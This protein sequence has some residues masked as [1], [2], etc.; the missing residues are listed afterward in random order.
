MLAKNF[1]TEVKEHTFIT[2]KDWKN[3]NSSFL[4]NSRRTLKIPKNRNISLKKNFEKISEGSVR[5]F[6]HQWLP[7][8]KWVENIDTRYTYSIDQHWTRIQDI[9]K[10]AGD[11]KY[12]WE[13]ARFS[14][15]YDVIRYDYHFDEDQSEFVFQQIEDFIE[16]NS[17]DNQDVSNGVEVLE[18]INK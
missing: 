7:I 10:E 3:S 5:F 15:L 4:F 1:P 14:F 8:S 11:I 18:N 9:S 17:V 6:N 13:K 16:S 12:V 2:F